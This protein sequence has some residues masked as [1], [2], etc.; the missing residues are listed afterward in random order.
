MWGIPRT[1]PDFMKGEFSMVKIY[2]AIQMMFISVALTAIGS[3]ISNIESLSGLGSIMSIVGGIMTIAALYRLRH[4]N[5]HFS[6]AIRLFWI[7][8]GLTLLLVILAAA[9][10]VSIVSDESY[11]SAALVWAIALL[12]MA[13]VV[14][15]LAL[16]MQYQLYSGF[17]ELRALRNLDYPPKRIMWCFY[18]AL[19][20]MIVSVISI[21]G[22]TALVISSAAGGDTALTAAAHTID[23][24]GNIM[25][26]FGTMMEA[27]HLWLIFTFM[28]SAKAALENE[29]PEGWS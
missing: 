13:V 28:Q 23:M 11:N 29:T 17:E 18:L 6:K 3:V 1:P 7:Y 22:I 16:A 15:I 26:V 8:M 10:L 2:S 4:E 5:S 12:V 27:I 14:L 19:I 20:S 9:M 21:S 24:A 25:L